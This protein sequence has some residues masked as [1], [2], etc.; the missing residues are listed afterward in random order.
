MKAGDVQQVMLGPYHVADAVVMEIDGDEVILEIPATRIRMGLHQSLGDLHDKEPE[1]D[2][3]FLDSEPETDPVKQELIAAGIELD[4][5][6]D[7][8]PRTQESGSL[9][10]MDLDGVD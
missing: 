2:R 6:D 8:T 5:D 3:L 4:E 7:F 1:K 10:D 9:R